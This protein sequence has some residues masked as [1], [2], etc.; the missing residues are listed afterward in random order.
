MLSC[1]G[2]VDESLTSGLEVELEEGAVE[3]EEDVEGVGGGLEDVD[4]DK[5]AAEDD[6]DDDADGV[7]D[8]E[9]DLPNAIAL[10][11]N[12]RATP[13]SAHTVGLDADASERSML[14][15]NSD[16]IK[17]GEEEVAFV[18]R[19]YVQVEDCRRKTARKDDDETKNKGFLRKKAAPLSSRAKNPHPT[20][21]FSSPFPSWWSSH[22]FKRTCTRI[23]HDDSRRCHGI[24]R[25]FHGIHSP[26]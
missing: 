6:V 10:E 16:C 7:L 3:L 22:N 23:P 9:P 18:S 11:V 8:V 5:D 26:S 21:E 17:E 25:R 12:V 15:L 14:C 19:V 1:S 13:T 2:E 20:S 4:D 24:Q